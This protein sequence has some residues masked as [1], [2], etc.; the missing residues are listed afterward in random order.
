[1]TPVI[2]VGGEEAPGRAASAGDRLGTGMR[3]T[4][5]AA[6]AGHLEP[7]GPI[8]APPST[9]AKRLESRTYPLW[10]YCFRAA[11]WRSLWSYSAVSSVVA[12]ALL[13][14][15][16]ASE[17]SRAFTGVWQRLFV[18]TL[19]LWCAVVAFRVFRSL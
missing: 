6:S 9:R 4:D 11:A 19:D 18:A 1:M 15:L 8:C 3:G 14:V 2:R 16:N 17:E 10:A 12:L 5:R 7:A 13:L